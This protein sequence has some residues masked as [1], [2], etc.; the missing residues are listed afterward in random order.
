MRIT[1]RMNLAGKSLARTTLMPD[2]SAPFCTRRMLV[3]AN[4]SCINHHPFH[5]GI[6]DQC[7]ENHLPNL[8]AW[9]L[10]S[11]QCLKRLWTLLHANILQAN[12]AIFRR[13]S[14]SKSPPLQTFYCQKQDVQRTLFPPD[15]AEQ[16]RFH[17]SSRKC[18]WY[19]ISL[20]KRVT[21]SQ[22]A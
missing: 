10:L 19:I 4:N 16:T 11:D 3:S 14:L 12:S 21:I 13:F 17:G 22:I 18:L 8:I 9:I 15:N 20:L 1:C 2:S 5:I 7:V 6:F